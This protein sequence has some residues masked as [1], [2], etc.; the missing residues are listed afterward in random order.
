M[1]IKEQWLTVIMI[2]C[3]GVGVSLFVGTTV[4]YE[5]VEQ[6]ALNCWAT[7]DEG[8]TTFSSV[9]N[10]AVQDAVAAA[11]AGA[12][13]K[14]AGYC[15]GA[16]LYGGHV[17]T[18]LI[19]KGLHLQ[20]GYTYTNWS[21]LDPDLYV[22]TLSANRAGRVL[23]IF[24]SGQLVTISDLRLINGKAPNGGGSGG[25]IWLQG[26]GE[27]EIRQS[28]I[29]SSTSGNGGNSVLGSGGA[30]GSGGGIYIGPNAIVTVSQS[31]L[32]NN[33]GGVGGNGPFGA[34]RGGHGGGIYNGGWL[35]VQETTIQNNAA[36]KAGQV[37]VTSSPGMGGRGGGIYHGGSELRVENSLIAD[38]RSGDGAPNYG[39]GGDGGG[40]YWQDGW[41]E[42]VNTTISNNQTGNGIDGGVNG[43]GDGLYVSSGVITMTMSSI[44][45]NGD[46][47][48]GGGLWV[49]D[50]GL[51]HVDSSIMSLNGGDECAG[52]GVITG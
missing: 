28:E 13:V 19:D 21:V 20:G 16:Q 24:N 5:D 42:V 39:H 45:H 46:G 29:L 7:A 34:G 52:L 26:G 32:M 15:E 35:L 49:A 4:A 11:V 3:W 22:T 47:I 30:A 8:V 38:N 10:T 14:V 50:G 31:V 41:G 17:Q 48:E 1:L 2:I 9:D 18:V 36:G 37:S 25:G 12:T 6:Q 40:V 43:V 23:L 44:V 27:L 33:Q 51:V